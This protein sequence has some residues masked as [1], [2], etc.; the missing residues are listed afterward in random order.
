M[1]WASAGLPGWAGLPSWVR[2]LG[3]AVAE[4]TLQTAQVGG[5]SEVTPPAEPHPVPLLHLFT[6]VVCVCVGVGEMLE[7][8]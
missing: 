4:G 5:D 1:A 6:Y 7:H 3:E 8:V 2:I